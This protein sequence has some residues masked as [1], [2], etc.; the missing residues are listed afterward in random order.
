[1]KIREKRGS[2]RK[3]YSFGLSL[4]YK[5]GVQFALGKRNGKNEYIKG[6]CLYLRGERPCN[7][8]SMIHCSFIT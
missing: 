2:C 3:L 7:E 8:R 5:K 4:R 6:E 1:M